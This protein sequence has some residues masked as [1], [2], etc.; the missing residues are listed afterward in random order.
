MQSNDPITP[1][2]PEFLRLA[3]THTL[4]PV[5]RRLTADLETP[6][7]AFLRLAADEPECFLLESVENGEKVGR[8]TFMG[9]RPYRKIT[10][11]GNSIHLLENGKQRT[12]LRL[13]V[14]RPDGAAPIE[15]AG[16]RRDRH[17][18]T[19]CD[20]ARTARTAS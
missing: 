9:I 3:R 12:K 15:I 11:R 13:D 8:Y 20:A 16:G 7:S 18:R 10:A 19:R 1:T 6:V 2:R 5:Y 4:I 17:L 14:S